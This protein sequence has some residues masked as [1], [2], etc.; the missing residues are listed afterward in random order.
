MPASLAPV[1]TVAQVNHTFAYLEGLYAI[2]NEKQVRNTNHCASCALPICAEC[3]SRVYAS[4]YERR[5]IS[6]GH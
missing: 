4:S 6:S 2:I 3:Q 1:M 5:W